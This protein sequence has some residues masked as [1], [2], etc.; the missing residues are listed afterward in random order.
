MVEIKF[1]IG[2]K[3]SKKTYK[4]IAS[5]ADA[6]KLFGKKIGDKFNGEVIGLNGYELQITGGSD[7]S[8]FPMRKDLDGAIRKKIIVT[9]S[10]GFNSKRKGQRKRRS[11]RGNTISAEIS[12]INCAV[13]KAGKDAIAKLLG[14]TVA[15]A[16]G[17]APAETKTEEPKPVKETP[18][19]EV[20]KEEPKVEEK[21]A[22]ESKAEQEPAVEEKKEE[23]PAEEVKEEPVQEAEKPAEEIKSE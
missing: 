10:I 7:K 3:A 19:E 14:A 17:E 23:T 22:E 12:Q 6:E 18:V 5:G 8:G 4:H 15:P 13:I 20:K 16:E 1:A 2:D 11:M 9:K 21:P